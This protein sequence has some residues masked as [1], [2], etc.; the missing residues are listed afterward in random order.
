MSSAPEVLYHYTSA[1]GLLGILSSSSLWISNA[2]FMNDAEELIH[3][4][5][6]VSTAMNARADELRA[7]LARNEPEFPNRPLLAVFED[8]IGQLEDLHDRGPSWGDVYLA[9]FC[10]DG[11]LLSQWR[12]Y[13]GSGGYALGLDPLKLQLSDPTAYMGSSLARVRYGLPEA[14]DDVTSLVESID[15][16]SGNHPGS[17]AAHE[18]L[19]VVRLL[20]QVKNPGFREE[21]EWRL[22]NISDDSRDLHFREGYSALIPYKTHP[23][24]SDAILSITIGPGGNRPLRERSVRQMV[25]KFYPDRRWDI[26]VTAS[27]VPLR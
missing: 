21:R 15:P 10:E 3:A 1:A 18:F 9:C 20:A 7:R 14:I 13:A 23:F 11:D 12:G 25:E 24:P 6:A 26:K 8:M 22:V 17:L 4:S 2:L 16:G 5:Q 19:T 27:Q